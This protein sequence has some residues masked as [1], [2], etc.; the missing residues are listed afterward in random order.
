[1]ST[2]ERQENMNKSAKIE[3]DTI[4]EAVRPINANRFAGY[5]SAWIWFKANRFREVEAKLAEK[6]PTADSDTLYNLV[7]GWFQEWLF[8]YASED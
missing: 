6:Y 3:N 1:M 4:A 5:T 2:T 8:N 7:E